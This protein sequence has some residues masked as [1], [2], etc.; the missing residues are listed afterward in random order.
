[1]HFNGHFPGE[2]GLVGCPLD[3]S[4][5][6]IPVCASYQVL[7]SESRRKGSDAPYPVWES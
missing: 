2:P 7:A 1:M 3:S 5:P 6:F 4:L